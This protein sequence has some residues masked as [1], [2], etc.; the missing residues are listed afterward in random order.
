[1]SD[2]LLVLNAGS[3]SLKW[4]VFI[5]EDPPGLLLRGQV[6]GIPDH[7]R[8]VVRA[9]DGVIEERACDAPLDHGGAI[10]LLFA[11]GRSG[12]LGGRGIHAVGHRVV[13]GGTTFAA[14]V[15]LDP[16]TIAELARLIPLAPLHQTHNLAAIRAV[17]ARAPSLPQ[18]A[19]FD[20]AFHR[21]Q[22]DV[23]QAFALP[24]RYAHEGVRRYGFHGLSYEYIA[25]AL[26]AI[27]QRAAEGRTIVAHL[28]NGA[29]L[30]AIYRGESIASTMS[31]TALDGLVM[32]TR[33]GAIDPGVLLHL[34]DRHGMSARDLERLLYAESGLLVVSGIFISRDIGCASARVLVKNTSSLSLMAAAKLHKLH[35]RSWRRQYRAAVLRRN[36]AWPADRLDSSAKTK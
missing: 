26:P 3:S 35:C 21:T 8:F 29:S 31:F 27:N 22:P 30:C 1:M 13:H 24:R 15:R 32:G 18:V 23:A 28:G 5:D 20:T 36:I 16:G 34:M 10:A 9:P 33:C 19:C 7:P 6:E 12:V 2:A 11:W 14:P 25:S 17:A 4:S